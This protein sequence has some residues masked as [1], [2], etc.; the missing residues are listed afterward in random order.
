MASVWVIG[1]ST[2]SSAG[3]ISTGGGALAFWA[4]RQARTP[5]PM[6]MAMNGMIGIPGTTEI[7][8]AA[9]ETMPSATGFMAS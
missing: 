6:E 5:A 8:P 2:G 9:A 4:R 3:L 1:S 7:T